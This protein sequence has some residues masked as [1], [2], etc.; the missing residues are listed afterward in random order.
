MPGN[1]SVIAN[2]QPSLSRIVNL[3]IQQFF[4]EPEISPNSSTLKMILSIKQTLSFKSEK[5]EVI[6]RPTGS[7]HMRF[8]ITP[9]ESDEG[10]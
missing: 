8:H 4:S 7:I 2:S 5:L 3:V 9:N 6:L 10:T 1:T